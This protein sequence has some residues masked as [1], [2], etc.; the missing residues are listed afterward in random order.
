[1]GVRFDSGEY[2]EMFFRSVVSAAALVGLTACGGGGAGNLSNP[3]DLSDFPNA[4]YG[5][6]DTAV[7][8]L[9]GYRV[10]DSLI[11]ADL[12]DTPTS[13]LNYYGVMVLGDELDPGAASVTGYVGQVELSVNFDNQ[14][15]SGSATN[16]YET[17]IDKDTGNPSGYIA[18][19]ELD[20]LTLALRPAT[21][22]PLG[23][24]TTFELDV[25]GELDGQ[26]ITG[27]LDD[28]SFK[29]TQR[30]GGTV[31]IY[32]RSSPLSPLVGD[33]AVP[34]FDAVIAAD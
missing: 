24:G 8:Y 9:T 20:T 15:I 16:F 21:W 22:D 32:A 34:T 10:S 26:N 17:E 33:G 18:D 13:D 11:E 1:M 23:T 27:T 7:N 2:A 19:H 14:L 12:P 31:G 4:S 29:N 5:D 30:V 3:I 25:T 28:G 6:L